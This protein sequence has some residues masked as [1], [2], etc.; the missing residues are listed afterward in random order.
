MKKIEN[1]FEISTSIKP[2]ESKASIFDRPHARCGHRPESRAGDNT[3]FNL[4]NNNNQSFPN[5][6]KQFTLEL[7]VSS[8]ILFLAKNFRPTENFGGV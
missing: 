3:R 6:S 4:N 8:I 2:F 1:N 7:L 5:L